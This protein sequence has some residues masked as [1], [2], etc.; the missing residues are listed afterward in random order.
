MGG[1]RGARTQPLHPPRNRTY[2]GPL[3]RVAAGEAGEPDDLTT[4]IGSRLPRESLVIPMT[5]SA[6]GGIYVQVTMKRP[7]LL[8]VLVGPEREWCA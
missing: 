3:A 8:L 7:L 2:D 5:A 4:P 6:T 1:H